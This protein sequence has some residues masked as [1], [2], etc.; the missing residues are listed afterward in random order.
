MNRTK[1]WINGAFIDIK[2][3]KI[4]VFDR[5]FLYG[6]GVF[7]T[8]RSYSGVIFKLDEHLKRLYASLGAVKI[9]APY[10]QRRMK[11]IVYRCL[12]AN[13]LKNAY[14]RLAVTRGE[15]RFGIGYKDSLTPNIV[16]VT[17]KFEDYPPW[18]YRRGISANVVNLRQN[19]Y[20]PLSR[21]KSLNFLI[22][23]LARLY[24]REKGFD[25]AILANTKGDIAE[26]ATSNIFIFKKEVLSTPSLASGILAGITRATVIG[27][28]KKSGIKVIEKR[29]SYRELL[30]AD[31]V[32]FTN[33]LAEIL[34]VTN[35]DSE[36]IGRGSPGSFTQT[37]HLSYQEEVKAT[38]IPQ[39]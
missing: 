7:E 33:S 29:I 22:Y 4:S 17:K 26:G 37:L 10:S 13:K 20:S 36:K 21:I 18:M 25:D 12:A 9:R 19:E 1:V 31:E 34:A 16:I 3:A 35:V 11:D 32:F 2:D 15:G 8:M 6:D 30:D 28:A 39:A 14:L 24:A 23:I 38:L 27:L 5:G